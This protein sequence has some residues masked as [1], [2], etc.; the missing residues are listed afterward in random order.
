MIIK[1]V[2]RDKN[3]TFKVEFTSGNF[4]YVDEDQLVQANIYGGTLEENMAVFLKRLADYDRA[5]MLAKKNIT[6]G[7]NT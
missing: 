7:G 1:E 4:I 5:T 2:K 6:K 3:R